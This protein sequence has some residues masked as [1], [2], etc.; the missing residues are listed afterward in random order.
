TP[1]ISPSPKPPPAFAISGAS[2]VQ[3]QTPYTL[4]LSATDPDHTVTS[5]TINWGDGNTQ[6]VTGN[7][8]SVMHTYGAGPNRYVISATATD[9]TGLS[10]VTAQTQSVQVSH[11]APIPTISGPSSIAAGST[12]T[13]NLAGADPGHTVQSWTINWGDGSAAQSITGNPASVTHTFVALSDADTITASMTDDV[14]S[15]GSSGGVS[16][17][18]VT[19][20]AVVTG[21]L[22]AVVGSSYT[23]SLSTFEPTGQSAGQWVVNWGD[24]TS[25]QTFLGTIGS[26]SH[27]YAATGSFQ[28]TA[29]VSDQQ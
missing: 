15:Y 1:P 22:S 29:T 5:W 28:V 23:V 17:Q 2:T 16:V 25:P 14:G 10:Y 27:V 4:N 26:A 13:L 21:P 6:A 11:V 3:E 9:D 18:V 7:P 24:G 20:P 8:S 12:Y 19:A